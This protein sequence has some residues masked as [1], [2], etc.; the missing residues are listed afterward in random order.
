[1]RWGVVTWFLFTTCL[2]TTLACTT[3]TEDRSSTGKA[4]LGVSCVFPFKYK[5]H[6]YNSCTTEHDPDGFLWCS[7]KVDSE[8]K[9]LQGNFGYCDSECSD[10]DDGEEID[11]EINEEEEDEEEFDNEINEEEEADIS[12]RSSF[13]YAT[14]CFA[15]AGYSGVCR[16]QKYCTKTSYSFSRT[17]G[18]SNI[19]CKKAPKRSWSWS[20]RAWTKPK[21]T[22]NWWQRTTTSTTA[23]PRRT[24][25][26]TTTKP[27]GALCG[28]EGSEPFVFG[29]QEAK[30]GQFPFMVSFV[31]KRSRQDVENFCGGVLITSR[32]VLTAAHCF[33]GR[34][35][36]E[37]SSR[38]DIDVRIGLSNLE[39]RERN[40]A[41]IKTVTLHPRYEEIK[42]GREGVINDLCIVTLD[43]EVSSPQVCLGGTR[44]KD[45]KNRKAVVIGFGKTTRSKFTGSQQ[46]KLRFAYLDEIT[47]SEC[48]RKY[49][50]YYRRSKHKP[51]ITREMICAGNEEADACSGDSGSPLLWLN[52][53]LRWMVGGVVSFGPSSCGNKAPGVYAKVET[54]LDWIRSHI[55]R[56]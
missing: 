35:P 18:W 33:K 31:Y 53:D 1:M 56:S 13:N 2:A 6:I 51:K 10:D 25:R 50:D 36:S 12:V 14:P 16:K 5:D 38:G 39:D 22:Q 49:N 9:H 44:T 20:E 17:C 41:N 4:K 45:R 29:G 7:T 42:G 48:Q 43:R 21:P 54:S 46:D 11:K 8:G 55:S 27:R 24:T 32:H 19:C 37:W 47:N 3:T 28:L 15:S 30:P 34:R 40:P 23:A 52:S 26:R